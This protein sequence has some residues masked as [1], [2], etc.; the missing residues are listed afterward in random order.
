MCDG[1]RDLSTAI[2]NVYSA[3]IDD[4]DGQDGSLKVS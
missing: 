2:C 1:D 3:R 4:S